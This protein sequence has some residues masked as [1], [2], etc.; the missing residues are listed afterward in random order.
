M[1]TQAHRT[2]TQTTRG[3]LASVRI[4]GITGC[5]T[6]QL[7]SG[8]I[9]LT[10]K[11]QE[12]LQLDDLQCK[13]QAKLAANTTGRQT[14]AFLL[15]MTIVGVPVA[16]EMEKAKQ[17][18]VYKS[19]MEAKGYSILPPNDNQQTTAAAPELLPSPVS[20]PPLPQL[21]ELK[22]VAAQAVATS[23]A[24]VPNRDEAAQFKK[25]KELFD[26][27]LI[28]K[29]EHEKKRKEILDRL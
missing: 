16:F 24:P 20:P 11:T 5:G 28:T 7:S 4:V 19:C 27:S 3:I 21:I 2:R 17:R 9:P 26:K 23:A 13:D 29:E 6:F 12:Q 8:V 18:E 15:G 10:R 14:G 22:P 1:N 25:L